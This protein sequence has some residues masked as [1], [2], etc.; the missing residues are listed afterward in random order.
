MQ[1]KDL[2]KVL[3]KLACKFEREGGNHEIWSRGDYNTHSQTPGNQG[4]Y[5][6]GSLT[7]QA[8]KITEIS[9]DED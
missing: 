1:K 6:K 3:G 9:S 8:K 4:R 7:N 5:G 2:E